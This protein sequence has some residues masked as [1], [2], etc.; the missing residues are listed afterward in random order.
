[1]GRVYFDLPFC[2]KS[3]KRNFGSP[4]RQGFSNFFLL[5]TLTIA[6]KNLATL[7]DAKIPLFLACFVKN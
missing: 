5:A 4:L 3:V 7:F 1:M 6:F 2:V